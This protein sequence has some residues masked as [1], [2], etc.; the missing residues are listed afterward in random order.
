[1]SSG[2]SPLR[3]IITSRTVAKQ[4]V[5]ALE[6]AGIDVAVRHNCIQVWVPEDVRQQAEELAA[7]LLEPDL[8][9]TH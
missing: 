1:M 9:P 5:Q 8:Y 4:L 3:A 7:H 2:L 6:Q